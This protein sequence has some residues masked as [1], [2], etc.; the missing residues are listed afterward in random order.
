MYSSYGGLSVPWERKSKNSFLDGIIT[1]G[2]YRD[3]TSSCFLRTQQSTIYCEK[4]RKKSIHSD[5][6]CVLV[7]GQP[8]GKSCFLEHDIERLGAFSI[9]SRNRRGQ[10]TFSRARRV[11]H[12]L[13]VRSSAASLL[14]TITKLKQL[15]TQ[16]WNLLDSTRHNYHPQFR[17]TCHHT[18]SYNN[19]LF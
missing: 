4:F 11:L 6:T 16:R 12:N 5:I 1:V 15:S 9:A 17:G 2:S 7:Y 8:T 3:F 13:F 18:S 14:R 10:G 19:F